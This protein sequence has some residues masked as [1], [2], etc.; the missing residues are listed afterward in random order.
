MYIEISAAGVRDQRE[1]GSRLNTWSVFVFTTY[2]PQ[3]KV[4]KTL[5]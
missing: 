4:L 3:G 5:R 2:H 1:W